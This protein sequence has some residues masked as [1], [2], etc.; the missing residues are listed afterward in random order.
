[1]L[2]Y[3]GGAE[4]VVNDEGAEDGICVECCNVFG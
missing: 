4:G 1:L 2:K 3:G